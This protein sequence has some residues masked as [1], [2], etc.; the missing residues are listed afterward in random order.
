MPTSSKRRV[1][2]SNPGALL[3]RAFVWFWEGSRGLVAV[4]VAVLG[5]RET[6]QH[7]GVSVVGPIAG[8]AG[9]TV[10]LK[11][12]DSVAVTIRVLSVRRVCPTVRPRSI[13]Y[14]H[15]CSIPWAKSVEGDLWESNLHVSKVVTVP[16]IV[17]G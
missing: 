5:R 17:F 14:D 2:G 16:S 10:L 8:Q 12:V 6:A 9:G 3:T 1:A 4:L 11:C 15:R 7:V 13:R